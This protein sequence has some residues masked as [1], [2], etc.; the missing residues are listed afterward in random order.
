MA[1]VSGLTLLLPVTVLAREALQADSILAV[2]SGSRQAVLNSVGFAA[3]GATVLTLLGGCLGYAG[4]RMPPRAGGALDLLAVV[5]FAVPATVIGIG[6]IGLWNR[7]GTAAVYGTTSMLLVGYAARF[8]P[9]T[10][11]TMAA[12]V[13]SIAVSHEEAAATAGASWVRTMHGVVLPQAAPGLL[14]TWVVAFVLAFGEIGTSL[15]IAP[16]GE[17]TLPI[18]VYTL[19]ANAPPGHVAV[20]A[21]GQALVVL[22]PLVA[23]SI[24]FP[25]SRARP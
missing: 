15:L 12:S 24:A 20:L 19:I 4:A 5:L 7:P 16:P 22:T 8:L 2:V 18:R 14:A 1:L 9:V 25:G 6:L 21:L 23:L 3:A 13:R 17:T 10:V 11:L